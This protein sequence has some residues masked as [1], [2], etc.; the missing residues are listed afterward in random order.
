MHILQTKCTNDTDRFVNLLHSSFASFTINIQL[1]RDGVGS[2]VGIEL[3]GHQTVICA[4]FVA[5]LSRVL[6]SWNQTGDK[7]AHIPDIG[8]WLVR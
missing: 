1:T 7:W 4:V 8:D 2:V 6:R 5:L 3:P